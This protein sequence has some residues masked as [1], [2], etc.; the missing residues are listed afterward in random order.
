M[1]ETATASL[2]LMSQRAD[3]ELLLA[4][5]PH[6]A[7][8]FYLSKGNPRNDLASGVYSGNFPARKETWVCASS[9]GPNKPSYTKTGPLK[10]LVLNKE[11]ET[12]L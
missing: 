9:K 5:A 4:T 3:G 2:G 8:Y 11:E 10:Y 12:S 6:A 7:S 1:L